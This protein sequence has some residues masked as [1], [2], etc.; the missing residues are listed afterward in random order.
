MFGRAAAVV[1]D[2]EVLIG[3]LGDCSES[4]CCCCCCVWGRECN[5]DCCCSLAR[6]TADPPDEDKAVSIPALRPASSPLRPLLLMLL[7]LLL[8]ALE[9][10]AGPT[11]PAKAATAAGLAVLGPLSRASV[12]AVESRELSLPLLVP[13]LCDTP[14]WDV[15]RWPS[16]PDGVEP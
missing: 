2:D 4:P 7:L 1:V 13:V 8:R 3:V 11:K 5:C 10:E 12:K 15:E 16:K 6:G 9:P 14:V